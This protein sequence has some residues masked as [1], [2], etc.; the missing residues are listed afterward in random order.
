MCN[1]SGLG[2]EIPWFMPRMN[3]HLRFVY[4]RSF[5]NASFL[6]ELE[7]NFD[8]NNALFP[9]LNKMWEPQRIF[10]DVKTF[11]FCFVFHNLL[12]LRV[13]MPFITLHKHLL[14]QNSITQFNLRISKDFLISCFQPNALP[15]CYIFSYSS[16]CFEPL[17]AHHQ[18]DLL[19]IHS[20][21]FFICHSSWV[22]T[23]CTGS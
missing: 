6:S 9:R 16:T 5:E 21:W 4:R 14:P 17:C 8:I 22:T 11:L 15:V 20:I 19:Y 2:R 18:E 23:Q 13:E 7:W 1:E 10:P 3:A 12:P